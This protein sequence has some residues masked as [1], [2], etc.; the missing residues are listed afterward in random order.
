M[1]QR[2]LHYKSDIHEVAY[3]GK[4]TTSGAGIKQSVFSTLA[5]AEDEA[6][7]FKVF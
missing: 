6:G 5:E 7:H 4:K 1:R 3:L 2:H